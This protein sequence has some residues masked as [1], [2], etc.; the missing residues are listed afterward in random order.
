[1]LL[2]LVVA[3]IL[4]NTEWAQNILVTQVTKKLSKSLHTKV[5]VKRVSFSLF[6][7]MY[8]EGTFVEDRNRDTLLYAGAVKVAITDWFFI[9]DQ[10]ELQYI[11]LDDAVI[12]MHRT[13]SVWNYQFLVDYFSSPKKDTAKKEGIEM[14][15]KKAVLN[16]VTFKKTDEWVGQDMTVHI[17]YLDA[18]GED[19]N[20]KKKKIFI[21][22][23]R[24][25]KPYFALYDYEGKR[26]KRPAKAKSKNNPL[27]DDVNDWDV[28]VKDIVLKDG[29]F[30]NDKQTGR[31][32]YDYFDGNHI[33]FSSINATFKNTSW[34]KDTVET[35]M[36]LST[37]ER[38]GFTVNSLSSR[39]K[40]HPGGMIFDKLDIKTPNSR[41]RNFYAMRYDDFDEDMKRFLHQVKLE[42]RF[43][44]SN[45][46]SD[47]LAYFAPEL[48]KWKRNIRIEGNVYGTIDNLTARNFIVEAG[49][50]SRLNGDIKMT[51]LPD[52]EKTYISFRSN[53]FRTTYEDAVNMVPEIKDIKQPNL[54]ELGYLKFKGTFTGY[55]RDFIT[56]GTIETKLGTV[57]TDINMKL[58]EGGLPNYS[59]KINT[60]SF[61]LGS[62]IGNNKLG[63]IAF[64][65]SIK[66]EGFNPNSSVVDVDGK[67]EEFQFNN[68]T[69]HN[70]N[71]KGS[72]QKNLFEGKIGID[73]PNVKATA[74]GSIDFKGDQPEFNLFAEILR[75]DLKALNLSKG[76]FKVLGKYQMNFKGKTIDDFLG[77]ASLYD[78]AITKND[79]TYIFDSL[80]LSSDI[81]DNRKT[82]R[83]RNNDIDA[84]ISGQFSLKDLPNTVASYL[85]KYYPAYINAPKNL[86]GKQSFS[87]HADVKDIDQY[88]QLVDPY[89]QGF[90]YT[91]IDGNINTI[92]SSFNIN[93]A[94]P[95]A[96][97]KK[98]EL[99][100]FVLKG[101][102]NLD[103][104]KVNA[105]TGVIVVNDSLRF[106]STSLSIASAGNISDLNITTGA[107]QTLTSANLS[108]RVTN[109]RDGARIH[110]NPSS[111]VLNQKTWRIERDGE[112]TI[113]RSLVDASEIMFT[114]GDQEISLSSIPSEIGNSNDIIVS[115]RRVNLGDFLP[116]V[117]TNPR[118]E[119]I[120]SGEV[121]IEDPFNKLRVYVNAQ[122][123]QTRFENDSIGIIS[124]NGFWDNSAKKSTYHLIS[125]NKEHFFTIN[126]SL[127][128]KDSLNQ[129]IDAT[130]DIE[131]TTLKMIERYLATI[132]GDL[133][134]NVSGKLRVVGNIR[135]PDIIG[136]AKVKGGGMKVLYTNCYYS[137]DDATVEFRPDEIDFGSITV[138]DKFKNMATV[139]GT[140][141]HHFFRDFAYD[142]RSNTRKLLLLNTTRMDNSTF[143]GTAIGRA[144]FVFS[145]PQK[146]MKM[147]VNA[148]PVDSSVMFINTSTSSK[149]KGEVDYIIWRQY[150][151]EMNTDSLLK[152]SSSLAIDLDLSSN[153][154]LK[155]NVILD[156]LTGDIISATGNGNIKLHTATAEPMTLNGRYNVL[157]GDYNFNFQDIFKKPFVLEPGSNSTISWSGDPYNADL[158]ITAKYVADKVQMSTLFP[159]SISGVSSGNSNLL[160]EV[161]DVEVIC[162]LTGTLQQPEPHFII[163]LPSNSALKTNGEVDSKLRTINRDANEASKQA[164]Y[165]IVFKS[166]APEAAVV[167]NEVNEGLINTTISGVINGILASSVKNFFYK[168]FGN[169][170]GV[171]FNYSRVSSYSGLSG[172]SQSNNADTR[173]NVSLQFIKSIL[174]NKLTISFGSDFNFAAVSQSQTGQS[175]QPFLFL[176]DVTAEYRITPD[177]KLR[178]SFFYKSSF[179][180]LSS[181]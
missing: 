15:L 65:G 22:S 33:Q 84:S 96:A 90:D 5:Q 162:N 101:V 80:L 27:Q 63:T 140:L 151:R 159:E 46:S 14:M 32:P 52:I 154:Y 2:L 26:P 50:D 129:R 13:D 155:V 123:D 18:D 93:V 97:Y 122:T 47:D 138:R 135:E 61:N 36:Q 62:F 54:A 20:F 132:F 172:T 55:L 165:L 108:A 115:L 3:A 34:Y 149:N 12:K 81:E 85:S 104:L 107:T 21:N 100:D 56:Y 166:F 9:K 178:A 161:S 69:Y 146:D 38:S 73:D 128:L 113:S 164:T 169:S 141:K 148:E 72:L 153:P 43:T 31:Q 177:G 103:S 75:S 163:Q 124:L 120:T 94:V 134:G 111:L 83:L 176:P 102:G 170:F 98:Y 44:G 139:G 137:F 40:I 23:L 116:F 6:N 79:Q 127:D 53:D 7:R 173:E 24:I 8:L 67:V 41:L 105:R 87:F 136:T 68:Y 57:N 4:I 157:R 125:A 150:G 82:I 144:A 17:K 147:Y 133:K 29:T 91:S 117:I 130:A 39:L 106:P 30:K 92:D 37:K 131:N 42:G 60:T 88:L 11:G 35:D 66:G 74:D 51:G 86:P 70:I 77:N 64:N 16:N 99:N 110:F 28:L 119:G 59:G 48:K 167:T 49:K 95:H 118:I 142:I 78:V 126:G 112:L 89:L 10:A 58:P 174:N 1:M 160:K 175:V 19:I 25:D 158:N 143:W 171:N 121:T 109:L 114:N 145:G 45:L 179:D 76:D 180:V 71:V 181:S 168:V 156:E 152:E